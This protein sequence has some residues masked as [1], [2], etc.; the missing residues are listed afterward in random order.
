MKKILVVAPGWYPTLD[1]PVRGSYVLEQINIMSDDFE[2]KVIVGNCK[3]IGRKAALKKIIKNKSCSFFKRV[4]ERYV[5]DA[6]VFAI[7]Y[8]WIYPLSKK[9]TIKQYQRVFKNF[10]KVFEEIKESGW[11]PDLIHFQT[12]SG[13]A[14][15]MADIAEKYNIP[16]VITEHC[17][18]SF[19][20]DFWW[21]KKKEIY[22]R[23]SRVFCVSHDVLRHLLIHNCKFKSHSIVGNYVRNDL[24]ILSKEHKIR[25]NI[26]FIAYHSTVKDF[27]V[28]VEAVKELHTIFDEFKINI[29]GLDP[30]SSSG[31]E[32]FDL[33]NDYGVNSYFEFKGVIP[34]GELINEL[35][36]NV[37][38][39][40]TS[41]CETF[42]LAVAEAILN[43]L[44]VVCTDS[45][46]IR[47]FVEDDNGIIVPIREPKA[48][49]Y[50]INCV[51]N[52]LDKY[53]AKLMSERIIL[54]YGKEA[55]AN[56]LRQ[57]Y[58]N[59]IKTNGK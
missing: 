29:I 20:S 12:L 59:V 40:S 41:H 37:M 22:G 17:E 18:Y 58:L 42:G 9:Q 47:E 28:L 39:V 44:P 7:D 25:N 16:M 34:R 24:V 53:D 51:L 6:D 56:K 8:E 48:V 30:T 19:Q 35:S 54:K 3:Q 46:G 23:V 14:I 50:A 45:G 31:V 1:F 11:Y 2:F 32:L 21:R 4:D 26:A 38:L 43:G 13:T 15:Y 36:K 27:S 55:F 49:A 5:Q 10:E 57:E 33:I 52:T